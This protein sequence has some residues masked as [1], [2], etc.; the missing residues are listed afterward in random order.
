MRKKIVSVLGFVAICVLSH[1]DVEHLR[2]TGVRHAFIPQLIM[3][4]AAVIIS[5]F[6]RPKPKFENAR[7]AALGDFDFPTA[8]EGRVI[9]LVFGRVKITGPN[10]VW[11]GDL[12]QV[13]MKEKVKTGLW[14]STRVTIGFRYYMGIQF[15]ICRGPNV[16]LKRVWI[17]DTQVYSG[18]LSTETFFDVDLPYVFG[19]DKQGG[20]IQTTVD[21]FPGNAGQSVSAYLNT[22]DRQ[23]I[24]TGFTHTAPRY[25][26]TCHLVA[27]ELTGLA[28]TGTEG[29]AWIGNSTQPKPWMFEVERFPAT[30]SGQ[31]GTDNKIGTEDANPINVIYELLTNAEW[32][33]G[34]PATSVDVGAGSTFKSASDTMITEAN[35][36]A[37]VIDRDMQAKDLLAELQR[38]IDGVVF[39]D[40]RTGKWRIKLARA[41]YAIGSVPQID[42]SD[43]ESIDSYTRGSWEDTTNQVQ[44]KFTKRVDNYK[45]SHALAQDMAN[46]IITGGGSTSAPQGNVAIATYPGVMNSALAAQIAWRHLRSI[47]YPLARV[48]LKLNRKNWDLRIGDV[49]AWSC[50]RLGITQMAMRVLRINYGTI[51][52]NAMEVSATQDIYRYAAPSMGTPAASGWTPPATEPV[53]YPADE[54]V[55]IEAPD[56]LIQRNRNLLSPWLQPTAWSARL[57]VCARKQTREVGY[58]IYYNAGSGYVFD[59]EATSFFRIGKLDVALSAGT[60]IPTASI[61]GIGGPDA[62]SAIISRFEQTDVSDMGENLTNLILV[63][64]EFMLVTSAQVSGSGFALQNVYRGALDTAQQNHPVNTPVYLVFVGGFVTQRPLNPTATVSAQLRAISYSG[65]FASP[66]TVTLTLNNRR[67]RPYPPACTLYNGG[68]TAFGGGT[69]NDSGATSGGNTGFNVSWRRRLWSDWDEVAKLLTDN[70]NSDTSHRLRIFVDPYNANVE[71]A[72]SPTAWATGVGPIFINRLL[73]WDE[74][75]AGTRIR[76]QVETR[77]TISLPNGRSWDG[78]RWVDTYVTYSNVTSLQNCIHDVVPTSPYSGLFYLGGKLRANVQ[79]NSYTAVVSDLYTFEIQSAYATSDVEVDIDGGGFVQVI[80]AGDTTGKYSVNAGEVVTIR[81]TVNETPSPNLITIDDGTGIVA[82]GV[83]KN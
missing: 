50:P 18:S 52:K 34:F 53:A 19:G 6:L 37:M 44:V 27:R 23:Q 59:T 64:T 36:F 45:E 46:A 63:G 16:V 28:A 70:T 11:Y 29:G 65:E 33:F 15:A 72:G 40:Q 38:Q 54:Q 75:A 10:V 30:F 69:L 24:T 57:L 51:D 2:Q 47:S 31:S 20:G 35:G 4:V 43:I 1:Y 71:I 80:P 73:L 41:D 48:T 9:P 55:V 12:D 14:S 21:F 8:T 5:E 79:S 42:D 66:S 76:V 83:L 82:Y 25:S 7:P 39:L 74:A 81:H 22:A 49:F 62:R 67:V 26:G 68:S 58:N 17:G 78:V 77:H 32:G 60:A 56:A 3:L 13:E 61:T